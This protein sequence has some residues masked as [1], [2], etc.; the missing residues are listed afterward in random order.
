MNAPR[1]Q[2]PVQDI[3][4]KDVLLCLWAG[5]WWIVTAALTGGL[6]AGMLALVVP[7][8]YEATVL[9]SPASNA[10]DGGAGGFGALASR[11]G[12]LA[13][14][15][16]ISVGADTSKEETTAYLR[17]ETIVE[18]YIRENDLLPVLYPKLW[19]SSTS[20]WTT[21]DKADEPTVWKGTR[22]FR[23]QILTVAKDAKTG[24]ITLTI[25]WKDP[26]SAA[27]WAN[28]LVEMGNSHLRQRAIRDSERNIEYLNAEAAKTSAVEARQAI[29]AV[30]Q[31]EINKAMLARGSQEYAYKVI[32]P[33]TAAELPVS[34][35]IR[36]W[37]GM[38]VIAGGLASILLLL[39]RRNFAST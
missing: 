7:E 32:D 14:L 29:Y 37:I 33:G 17:S 34:P 2:Q 19:N 8:R 18:S 35:K 21:S 1:D 9:L 26:E 5:K 36:L 11:F 6:S 24:L 3:D 38:G 31:N 12:G 22:L 20:K 10:G 4:L 28:G 27:R 16:G 30:L 23:S 15:A 25:R 39:L 13:S